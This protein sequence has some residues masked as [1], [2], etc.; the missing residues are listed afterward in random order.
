[1][2][3]IVCLDDKRGMFFN[4]RRQSRDRVLNADVVKMTE[5]SRLLADPYSRILFEDICPTLV[6]DGNFLE[7]AET[8][9]YC[10]VENRALSNCADRIDEIII[11]WW[12]RRYP[13]DVFFDI[14]PESLGFRRV[15]MTEFE[16]SSHEK[17]TKEIFAR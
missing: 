14:D 5:G 12:N 16:G 6:C 9:D 13:T 3:V 10:F 4:E 2:K 8:E 11:Y 7:I 17:I 15:S 1:M